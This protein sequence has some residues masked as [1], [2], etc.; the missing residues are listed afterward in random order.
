MYWP[1]KGL[2]LVSQWTKVNTT[3]S[4]LNLNEGYVEALTVPKQL[5]KLIISFQIHLIINYGYLSSVTLAI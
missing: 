5:N 4:Y 2:Q 1:P 3:T